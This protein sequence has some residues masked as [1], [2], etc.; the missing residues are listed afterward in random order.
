MRIRHIQGDSVSQKKY[1]E[2]ITIMAKNA[3]VSEENFNPVLEMIY[4]AKQKAEY[5]V[6]TTV[7]DLYWSI[8]KYVSDKAK[9]DGWGKSTVKDLSSYI[10]SKEP[11]IRG[12]SAQNI[13]R[14]KQRSFILGWQEKSIILHV[15]WNVR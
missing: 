10:L 12:Y 3:I 7:I 15:S 4:S 5:Q 11:G 8:G 1:A 2:R 13:W 9:T 6:N 14:M